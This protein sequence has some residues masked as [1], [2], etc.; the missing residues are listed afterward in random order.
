MKEV[1]LMRRMFVVLGLMAVM[2]AI[3]ALTAGAALAQAQTETSIIR[4]SFEII[5]ENRCTGEPILIEGDFQQVTHTTL[6]ENGSHVVI[7]SN[8]RNVSAT[9]LQTGD[10]YLITGTAHT[11]Q[12]ELSN[13]IQVSNDGAAEVVVSKDGSPNALIHLLFKYTFD[14]DDGQPSMVVEVTTIGCT[15]EVETTHAHS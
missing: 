7:S 1:V 9:G 6:S 3:A 12:S 4:E 14:A 10:E 13:G 11:V 2:A 5:G 8:I 15:P